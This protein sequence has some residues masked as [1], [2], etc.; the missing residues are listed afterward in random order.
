MPSDPA[1]PLA[2][3]GL[4]CLGGSARQW[5]ALAEALGPGFDLQGIDLPGFGAAAALPGYPVAEMAA[6]VAARIA[7][8]APSRWLLAGH[9]MGA[10][11][12]AVLARQ[13]LDGA[14][15]LPP[16]AGLVTLAGSPPA[17]EPMAEAR[18][19]EMT[20]WLEGDAAARDRHARDFVAAN[21][22]ALPEAARA[23]AEAEML[24]ASPAAWRAWLQ[25]GSREDWS[26]RVGILPLPALVLAGA[27]DGDLGPAAQ[28]RLMLPH[29]PAARLEVIP[30]ARHLLPIEAPAAVARLIRDFAA[31]L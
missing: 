26:D 10:K 3:F 18:R 22:L 2:L 11:V 21:A 19:A 4:P 28:R 16:P 23:L 12:A 6:H 13:A 7:A 1:A 31:G 14:A 24:R 15:P 30:G 9:S 17:P 8:A 25:S 29:F 5:R 27:E 20:G